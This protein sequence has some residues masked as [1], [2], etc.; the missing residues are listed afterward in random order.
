MDTEALAGGR[1]SLRDTGRAR[2][3]EFSAH[4]NAIFYPCMQ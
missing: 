3:R 2:N 4:A 1:A